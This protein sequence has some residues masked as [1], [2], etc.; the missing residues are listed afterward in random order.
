MKQPL[1]FVFMF[2]FSMLPAQS[3]R[4][5]YADSYGLYSTATANGGTDYLGLQ[6]DSVGLVNGDT[7]LYL[8]KCFMPNYNDLLNPC[9]HYRP[10]V[11]CNKVIIKSNGSNFLDSMEIHTQA[12]LDV[13][14]SG[15]TFPNG[16]RWS[17]EVISHDTATLIGGGLDSIKTI[18]FVKK[19]NQGNIL[20]N[21]LNHKEIRLSKTNG[22]VRFLDYDYALQRAPSLREIF[23]FE[24][25]DTLGYEQ[26]F[27]NWGSHSYQYSLKIVTHKDTSI[28]G[29]DTSIC[30]DFWVKSSTSTQTEQ[31]CISH[32]DSILY[33]NLP[34][35]AV[36][37]GQIWRYIARKVPTEYQGRMQTG[38]EDIA[39]NQSG[40]G[41]DTCYQAPAEGYPDIRLYSTGLG[42]TYTFGGSS[43]APVTWYD[44]LIYYKKG[45]LQWGTLPYIAA[46]QKPQ[47]FKAIFIYPNPTH[48]Y[49][50][51]SYK[52]LGNNDVFTFSISDM[53]GQL[54]VP[55]TALESSTTY[56]IS[57]QDWASGVYFV[58]VQDEKGNIYTE[59]F[60]KE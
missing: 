17:C 11:F 20:A 27:N 15:Y 32:L 51:I 10:H 16:D 31:L 12:G 55:K 4:C 47:S 39:F 25:G 49:L 8:N 24:V 23:D 19:D 28:V 14:W 13:V 21:D 54:L 35:R 2:V 44:K 18:R 52:E 50:N 36:V 43:G 57:L 38:I 60:I 56:E 3:Y 5:W 22:I 45:N 48:N 42:L 53:A 40:T 59:K 41:A 33:D 30:Y 29:Q 7:V 58:Q 46:L 1:L 6:I 26:G 37:N 34:Y 9:H